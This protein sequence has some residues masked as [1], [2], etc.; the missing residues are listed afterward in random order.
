MLL[1][2]APEHINGIKSA[3]HLSRIPLHGLLFSTL[4][5]FVSQPALTDGIVLALLPICCFLSQ[6]LHH[7]TDH[8]FIKPSARAR[9]IA[10]A[11][12]VAR[13]LQSNSDIWL[14]KV[15]QLATQSISLASS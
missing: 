8:Y 4:A 12:V 11:R 14:D 2:R 10:G 1:V 5:I 3:C 6:A 9:V 7:S 15:L 13:A